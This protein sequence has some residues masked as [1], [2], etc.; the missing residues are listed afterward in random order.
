MKRVKRTKR[1]KRIKCAYAIPPELTGRTG[2]FCAIFRTICNG[3]GRHCVGYRKET[4]EERAYIEEKLAEALA[5]A[6]R[7]GQ[8]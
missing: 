4:P 2:T 6:E 3:F 5:A 8:Q 7:K 1:I